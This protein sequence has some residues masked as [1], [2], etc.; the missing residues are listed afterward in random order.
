[1]CNMSSKKFNKNTMKYS[2]KVLCLASCY[3]YNV[4]GCGQFC[5]LSG[6]TSSSSV[7]KGSSV[8][9]WCV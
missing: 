8:S 7:Y 6:L 5:M 1:M 9:V 2:N 4:S 3:G